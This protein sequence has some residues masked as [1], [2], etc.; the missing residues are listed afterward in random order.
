MADHAFCPP[1]DSQMA[2]DR[3]KL[4]PIPSTE[5]DC[6][7]STDAGVLAVQSGRGARLVARGRLGSLPT[8]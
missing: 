3:G 6:L 7:L 1:T 8:R 2:G 4:P 5:R